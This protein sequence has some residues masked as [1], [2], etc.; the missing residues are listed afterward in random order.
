M[1]HILKKKEPEVIIRK[2]NEE[3]KKIMNDIFSLCSHMH[4]LLQRNILD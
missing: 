2:K 4:R 1:S 3:P